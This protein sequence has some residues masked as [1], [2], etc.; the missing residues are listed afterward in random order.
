M[1]LQDI[2]AK[3]LKTAITELTNVMKQSFGFAD[4]QQK[5]SLALGMNLRDTRG[6]LGGTIDGLR[7]SIEKRFVAGMMTLEAGLQGNSAGVAKLINQQQLTGGQAQGTAKV[8]AKLI[9]IGG[10][11]ADAANALASD[12]ISTGNEYGVSTE[13]LVGALNSLESN[14]A[15][16]NLAEMGPQ[17]AGAMSELQ[18]QLGPEMAGPLKNVMS[19]VMDTSMEGYANLTKLGIGGV[20][21]QLAAATTTAEATQILKDAFVTA[22]DNFK[23]VAG[24]AKNAYFQVGIASQTFGDQAKYTTTL[25][26]ALTTGLRE[27]NEADVDYADSLATMKSEV[28]DPLKEAFMSLYV[29]SLPTLI[30]VFKQLKKWVQDGVDKLKNWYVEMGGIENIIK[31]VKEKFEELKPKIINIGKIIGGVL[32]VAITLWLVSLAQATWALITLTVGAVGPLIMGFLSMAAAVL[33]VIWPILAVIAAIALVVGIFKVLY[34]NVAIV[35]TI[36]DFVGKGLKLLW[37]AFK[38]FFGFIFKLVMGAFKWIGGLA[39][40]VLGPVFDAFKWMGGI[41]KD[42][43]IAALESLRDAIAGVVSGFGGMIKSLGEKLGRLPGG[44]ALRSL[45]DGIQSAGA[46][47]RT[48]GQGQGDSTAAAAAKD[49][50]TGKALDDAFQAQLDSD[51]AALGIA[52]DSRDTLNSI[53]AKTPDPTSSAFMDSTIVDLSRSIES[54]L[55]GT[56]AGGDRELQEEMLV[57]LGDI[58]QST[59]TTAENAPGGA[60]FHAE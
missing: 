56:L 57:T 55:G 10:V 59:G 48:L 44:S 58:A 42:V 1:P 45:G 25:S 38:A 43:V 17:V 13:V 34:K 33:A 53:D 23:T 50:L 37:G 36:F 54:I 12:M 35:K 21:E 28:L 40:K 31:A 46:R 49:P 6:K 16:M 7:G 4:R 41:V 18:A 51:A 3:G 52:E 9:K 47:L 26:E 8:F 27:R 11:Q 39:M 29:A 19:M 2:A 20:R 60:G 24:D 14:M 5:S 22:S 15:A 32:L 30:A